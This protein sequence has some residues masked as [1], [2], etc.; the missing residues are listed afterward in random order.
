MRA[1]KK[2]DTVEVR[3]PFETKRAFMQQCRAQGLTASESIRRFI[4]DEIQQLAPKSLP[5]RIV[6]RKGWLA[7][8]LALLAAG[9]VAAPSLAQTLAPSRAVFT[10]LDRNGDG[11]LSFEEFR[12]R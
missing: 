12:A 8:A 11:V 5:R 10:E 2:T 7:A 9:A 3:I 4:D 6:S 1:P